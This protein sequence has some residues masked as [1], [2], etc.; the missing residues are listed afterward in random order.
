MAYMVVVKR[1]CT[2][3]ATAKVVNG[4]AVVYVAPSLVV[5]DG[6]N[7]IPKILDSSQ[8]FIAVIW[9]ILQHITESNVTKITNA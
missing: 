1:Y 6:R 9:Q 8:G 2:Y 7:V 4:V 5:V 3:M